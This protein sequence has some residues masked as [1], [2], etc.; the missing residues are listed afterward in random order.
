METDHTPDKGPFIGDD[1]LRTSSDP[2]RAGSTA[3]NLRKR[4]DQ[5]M[6]AQGVQTVTCATNTGEIRT[7]QCYTGYAGGRL[8]GWDQYFET[9]LQLHLGWSTDL[10]R[11]GLCLFLD[12]A[13]R[14]GYIP[15]T[16]PRIWWG[17]F[18]QQ[19]F[20]CQ[21][22]LLLLR[23]GDPM[24]WLFPQR[25]YTLKHY[26]LRW[27]VN[28]DR[29]GAGLSTWDHSG[30]SGMD[31]Q[32]ERAG[33]FHDAFCEGVDLNAYLVRECEAMALL[34]DSVGPMAIQ[35][36][37]LFRDHARRRRDAMQREC[38][39]ESRGCYLDHHARLHRPIPVR[40][41]GMFA[42]LWAGIP[43]PLQARRL[44]EEHLL[45]K[46]GFWRPWPLPALA[47]D[48]PGYTEGFLEWEPPDFACSWRAHS[49]MPTNYI[50][51]QGLL[52]YGFHEIARQLATRNRTMF[53]N[54][55]FREYYGAESGN[56]MG[57]NPFWGWS[58][59]AL[60]MEEECRHPEY[61]R[62]PLFPGTLNSSKKFCP[63]R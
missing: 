31:N 2:A 29:R 19:P 1:A 4:L 53:E 21:T 36:A 38:W 45:S 46:D 22:A 42:T 49:W 34:A 17:E 6:R 35:D 3:K 13:D 41:V 14:T 54:A 16:L 27:L 28:E 47:V 24:D 33:T 52:R 39:S 48:E 50:A 51:V 25:Y 20:L 12:Q 8:Y 59:L 30:H 11:A 40:H 18:H 57:R 43:S 55:P 56:G 7:V 61:G 44:V 10:S 5:L 9:I 32:Y 60:F 23:A 62:D 15:R 63:G 37:A 58:G 26:L